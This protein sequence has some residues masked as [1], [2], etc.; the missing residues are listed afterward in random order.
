MAILYSC[1]TVTVLRGM[2]CKKVFQAIPTQSPS[3][4]ERYVSFLSKIRD[5][6]HRL[7]LV[8]QTNYP[9]NISTLM[10]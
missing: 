4:F 6:C 5:F 3:R 9:V 8:I 7:P 2:M 10:Y 1:C